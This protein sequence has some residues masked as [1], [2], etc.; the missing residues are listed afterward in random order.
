MLVITILKVFYL[1]FARFT[2]NFKGKLAKFK[3][4]I[5]LSLLVEWDMENIICTY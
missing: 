3:L 2:I 1:S 5:A 4:A